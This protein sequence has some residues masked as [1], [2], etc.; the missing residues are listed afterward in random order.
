MVI[1]SNRAGLLRA[2]GYLIISLKGLVNNY[3]F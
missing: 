3:T 2:T 1:K